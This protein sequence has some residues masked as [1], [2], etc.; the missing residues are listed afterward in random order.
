MTPLTGSGID[1]RLERNFSFSASACDFLSM[2]GFDFG[3]L[4]TKGVPYLSRSEEEDLRHEYTMHTSNSK[5]YEDIVLSTEDHTT[6]EFYRQARMTVDTWVKNK[7][8]RTC[9]L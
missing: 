9:G 1:L 5:K 2:N 6:M 3:R 7:K 8:V 4:F